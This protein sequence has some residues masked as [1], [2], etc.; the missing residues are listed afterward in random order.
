VDEGA[1]DRPA[2]RVDDVWR[3][4]LRDLLMD[5][6]RTLS[7]LGSSC[8]HLWLDF[9]ESHFRLHAIDIT[10]TNARSRMAANSAPEIINGTIGPALSAGSEGTCERSTG[11]SAVLFS[12]DSADI[13]VCAD[14]LAAGA[15]SE[16]ARV[17]LSTCVSFGGSLA[18]AA[19]ADQ[20]MHASRALASSASTR[21]H[22]LGA[23]PTLPATGN[24]HLMCYCQLLESCD[25]GCVWP[26]HAALL[27]AFTCARARDDSKR[28][29]RTHKPCRSK[30]HKRN[31][32]AIHA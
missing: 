12:L 17:T 30:R 7:S 31:N 16:D 9:P 1:R 11:A 8:E 5:V 18:L 19:S 13:G 4:I 2:R 32:P 28:I 10:A 15:C 24:M 26:S 3:A 20:L 23:L 14:V 6:L 21:L 25:N 29:N 27:S 22:L